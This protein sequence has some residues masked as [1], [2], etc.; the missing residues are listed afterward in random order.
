M[1]R[2]AAVLAQHLDESSP[3]LDY[4]CTVG[5]FAGTGTNPQAPRQPISAAAAIA[6]SKKGVSGA[7]AA[8]SCCADEAWQLRAAKDKRVNVREALV[9]NPWLT[10]SAAREILVRE[11]AREYTDWRIVAWA[12]SRL[13]AVEVLSKFRH[14]VETR[15]FDEP[16]RQ[17][18][19]AAAA[20][21]LLND[22]DSAALPDM[23]AIIAHDRD[24][25]FTALVAGELLRGRLGLDPDTARSLLLSTSPLTQKWVW[26]ALWCGKETIDVDVARFLISVRQYPTPG[27]H[28]PVRFVGG[29]DDLGSFGNLQYRHPELTAAAAELLAEHGNADVWSLVASNPSTPEEVCVRLAGSLGVEASR[30]MVQQH[31]KRSLVYALSD[32]VLTSYKVDI[33]VVRAMYADRQPFPADQLTRVLC[34]ATRVRYWLADREATMDESQ[35]VEVLTALSSREQQEFAKTV[36]FNWETFPEE[37]R[38]LLLRHAPGLMPFLTQDSSYSTF[39]VGMVAYLQELV[40]VEDANRWAV[41]V[42]LAPTW[43]GTIPA[44]AAATA[45]LA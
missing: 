4:L 18:E 11:T 37:R 31:Q 23:I 34:N 5:E 1:S 12:T 33:D 22:R 2:L 30:M 17:V 26:A 42:S 41:L 45:A 14:G 40:G 15:S 38:S 36:C 20:F 25:N 19:S 27:E 8:A 10:R 32:E 44:L 21:A 3:A 9:R 13:G 28:I 29:L 35:V 43:N 16:V 7:V 6:A 39:T 24:G